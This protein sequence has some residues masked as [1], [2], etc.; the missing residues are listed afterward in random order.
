MGQRVLIVDDH[1]AFAEAMVFAIDAQTDLECVGTATTVDEGLHLVEEHAPDV[2]LVDVFLPGVDG[3][4]GTRRMKALRPEMRVLILTGHTELD[5]LAQAAR[6][7]AA[8]FL[9]KESSLGEVLEAVRVTVEGK[10]A[11]ESSTLA[12]L[13]ERLR[14]TERAT[15]R[16]TR[17][18]SSRLTQRQLEVLSLMR[19]G[20]DPQTIAS[21]LG[22][23]VHT[24]RGHV[25]SVLLK[26]GAHSQL[27]AVVIAA[28]EGL[29][30]ELSDQRD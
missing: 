13:I 16:N 6:A 25:K 19:E 18:T 14:D 3:I 21:R 28:R 7:G 26:L 2:A 11:V 15:A 12:A 10:I 30:P 27:G 17:H 8:G 4:E 24:C 29:L 22:I 1:L 23:S 5:V 9:P 20:L